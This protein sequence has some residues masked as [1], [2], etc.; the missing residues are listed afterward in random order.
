MFVCINMLR[1]R[2]IWTYVIFWLLWTC[3]N[4]CELWKFRPCSFRGYINPTHTHP[5]SPTPSPLFPL[6]PTLNKKYHSFSHSPTSSHSFP[7][8]H[9][10]TIFHLLKI[11]IIYVIVCTDNLV[12]IISSFNFSDVIEQLYFFVV[13]GYKIFV[14]GEKAYMVVAVYE[15][16]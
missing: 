14:V 15:V 1:I 10:T 7:H 12:T 13:V 3:S 4:V 6:L 8:L 5:L 9:K 2:K 11:F 16:E